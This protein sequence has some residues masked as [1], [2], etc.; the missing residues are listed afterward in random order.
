[1]TIPATP[2][3]SPVYVGNGV[4]T[5]FGFGFKTTDPASLVVTVA[6]ANNLNASVLTY[7]SDYTVTLNADQDANPGGSIEYTDLP[8]GHRLVITSDVEPSQPTSITNLG[9]FHA[10]V[11]EGAIDRLAI[12][13]QQLQE[14][15][16][17][18][19]SVPV[20]SEDNPDEWLQDALSDIANATQVAV[21]AANEAE[22]WA[23]KMDGAVSAGEFSAKYHAAQAALSSAAALAAKGDAE[24]AKLAAEAAQLAAENARD[25]AIIAKG[26]AENAQLAAESARD[27]AVIAKGDAESAQSAAESARDDA[28]LALENFEKLYLGPKASDPATDNQGGTLIAGAMY[29]NTT[30]DDLRVWDGS[31]WVVESAAGAL[32]RNGTLPMTG[33]LQLVDGSATAPA[34]SFASD[35]DTGFYRVGANNF[36]IA[37]GG[38]VRLSVD[39]DKFDSLVPFRASN[40]SASAPT[41]SFQGST[42]SGMYLTSGG[43]AFAHAGA[44]KVLIAPSN[45]VFSTPALVPNGTASA[46]S[47]SFFNDPDTG[48][49]MATANMLGF[50]TGGVGRLQI[51]SSGVQAFVPFRSDYGSVSAPTYS[52]AGDTD[53]GM[54]SAAANSIGFVAGGNAQMFVDLYAVTISVQVRGQGSLGASAPTY[55]FYGDTATGLYRIGAGYL[56]VSLAGNLRYRFHPAAFMPD[57]DNALA[58]GDPALRWSII[59]AVTGTINTSDAREKTE[60]APMTAAEI[61]A[62]RDLAREIGTFQWLASVAEKGADKARRHVGLTVQ[63]AIEIMESHGLDP[64][65]YAFICYDEWEASA[66]GD[67]GDRYSFRPDQLNLFIARGLEARITALEEALK[68]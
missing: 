53:T 58:I 56:G 55:S 29:W 65:R 54:Y 44:H 49:Y 31:A 18:S 2:R 66:D 20:T 21:D 63:R 64:M 50:A 61:A 19:V 3:R 14:K 41:F 67:A 51:S 48:M 12:L 9:A 6:D 46:P 38:Q 7:L 59:Y 43:L 11:L 34:V 42:G 17:R 16:S 52:F 45:T 60:V 24:S 37:T 4:N 1:M 25:A 68:S 5:T 36:G 62:A 57:P 28:E 40:G 15:A 22:A 33:V 23:I 32:P 10:H 35:P 13:I 30:T 39:N 47:V 26:D 27:T 8:V